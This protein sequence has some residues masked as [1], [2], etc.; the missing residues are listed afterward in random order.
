[1]TASTAPV[2]AMPSD[3]RAAT[4]AEEALGQDSK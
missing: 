4:N 2:N 3:Y 1:M